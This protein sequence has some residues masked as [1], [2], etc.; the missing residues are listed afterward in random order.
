MPGD[1]FRTKPHSGTKG[2]GKVKPS[3]PKSVP[4]RA[5]GANAPKGGVSPGAKGGQ[6][7]IGQPSI[8]K[9]PHIQKRSQLPKG[10]GGAYVGSGRRGK[11]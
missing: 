8:S 11:R 6:R 2:L 10:K 4:S 3:T 1:P 7:L 5:P 9:T